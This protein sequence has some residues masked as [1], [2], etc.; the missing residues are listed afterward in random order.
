MT[1][2]R[3]DVP[4]GAVRP[5]LL[6]SACVGTA[7]P[8]IQSG[9]RSGYSP[10]RKGRATG[11]GIVVQ[12]CARLI[13]E[14]DPVRGVDRAPVPAPPPEPLLVVD[15]PPDDDPP[16]AL[17]WL[18]PQATIENVE[19]NTGKSCATR[20]D[21]PLVERTGFPRKRHAER[22]P[23][24]SR[25]SSAP[26]RRD[27]GARR[28]RGEGV[29][30]VKPRTPTPRLF[31]T[32]RALSASRPTAPERYRGEAP[33]QPAA[34]AFVFPREHRRPGGHR[35]ERREQPH[36]ADDQL[37]PHAACLLGQQL[38]AQVLSKPLF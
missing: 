35:R 37:G 18:L 4:G 5:A 36:V 34:R 16:D 15:D 3:M 9:E 13:V 21:C 2:E 24:W 7:L 6:T 11:V 20:H 23:A 1:T 14:D 17:C 32:F 26:S 30:P 29:R 10:S 31:R 8:S 22:T 25:G 19:S 12:R 27:R 33:W 28:R 38:G